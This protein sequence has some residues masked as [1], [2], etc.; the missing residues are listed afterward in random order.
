MQIVRHLDEA[1]WSLSSSI[2]T[3]GN[4]DGLHRGHRVLIEGAVADALRLSIPSVV[5]TF[6]PHPLKVLAPERAPKLILAHKDKLRM[7]QKFRVSIV[8]VQPFDRAFANLEGRTFVRE[9]LRERLQARKIWVGRDFRF[10]RG[11]RAAVEQLVEWGGEEGFEVEAVDP[12]VVGGERV[13]SSRIR[14]LLAG[15]RVRE[16]K[17]M[18]GRYHFI[19]GRVIEGQRRGRDLG[20][21]TANIASR[22]EVLPQDGIYATLFQR[23]SEALLSVSSIGVNPTFGAGPRTLESY[24]L[25]FNENLYGQEITLSFVERLRPEAKFAS[26][27]ELVAQIRRDVANARAVFETLDIRPGTFSDV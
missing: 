18:L 8:A 17:S 20:F 26:V 22:T 12:I 1:G 13:S 4:F 21:P 14:E 25:D 3:L 24:I 15:G 16:A 7:L 10:G 11:R 2:V 27:P 6:E 19:S 5:L 9:L 23:G